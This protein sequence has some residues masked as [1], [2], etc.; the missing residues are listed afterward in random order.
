MTTSVA[1]A[2][3]W[4]LDARGEM[5]TKF[6]VQFNPES[7]KVSFT[8]QMQPPNQG[9]ADTSRGTSSTQYVGKGATKMSVSLWFDVNA[10]L[11]EGL[12]QDDAER[13]D[14]RALTKKVVDLIRVDPVTVTGE[15]PIPPAVR[16]LWGSFQFDG[17]IESIEQSLEFFSE[18]GIPQRA[19]LTLSMTQ[20]SI[21]YA[22][23]KNRPKP[24]ARGAGGN[25][26]SGAAPG[27]GRMTPAP[28]GA[29]LQGLAAAQGLG[30]NWTA[31]AEAN[32]IENP[33][34]LAPGQLIDM[35]V[36]PRGRSTSAVG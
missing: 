6:P 11:P 7:L 27:T 16:F 35:N 33:R 24:S 28:A 21:D 10:E 31:I 1:K 30:D 12:A 9:A 36:P 2:E 19:N 23:P 20:Q 22:F 29:T 8:N 14:V 15:Q 25:L 18:Q 32:G 17:L 13:G 3:L 4:K 34:L 26:P 5:V